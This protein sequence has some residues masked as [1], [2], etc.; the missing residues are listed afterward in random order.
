MLTD[1]SSHM[2][3]V[4]RGFSVPDDPASSLQGLCSPSDRQAPSMMT[5]LVHLL[6]LKRATAMAL[7]GFFLELK[8]PLRVVAAETAITDKYS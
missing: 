1:Q 4:A 6:H 7:E 5:V 3:L 8:A 2:A